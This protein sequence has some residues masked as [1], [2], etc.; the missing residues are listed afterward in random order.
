MGK[1]TARVAAS[2]KH[3][4]PERWRYGKGTKL[5]FRANRVADVALS[6][7]RLRSAKRN[8]GVGS[9]VSALRKVLGVKLDRRTHRYRAAVSL[10][11]D[12]YADVRVRISRRKRIDH[13]TMKTLKRAQ[14]DKFARGLLRRRA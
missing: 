14:L 9:K 4:R 10:G 11:G 5:T 12:R 8:V 6:D 2:R 1:P 13:I 3:K 7:K